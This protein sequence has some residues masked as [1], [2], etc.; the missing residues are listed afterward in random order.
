VTASP[1]VVGAE[2]GRASVSADLAPALRRLAETAS[3]IAAEKLSHKVDGWIHSL[4]GYAEDPLGRAALEGFKAYLLGKNPVWMALKGAWWG[5]SPSLRLVAVL[6]LL[7]VLLLAPVALLL[8]L[9]GLLL[10]AIIAG[11]RAAIR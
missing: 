3:Q 8:L 4:E 1:S 7:L 2:L 9:L 10:A 6:L 11:I 5:A